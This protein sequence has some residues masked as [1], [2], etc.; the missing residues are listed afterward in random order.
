M[1]GSRARAR[2]TEGSFAETMVFRQRSDSGK[3]SAT[4]TTFTL[5]STVGVHSFM[6]AQVGELCVSLVADFALEGLDG[7]VDVGVLL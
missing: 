1:G 3:A 7:R 5:S 6:P 4:I 2:L